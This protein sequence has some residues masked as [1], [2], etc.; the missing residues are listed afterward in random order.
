MYRVK[1]PV[2]FALAGLLVSMFGLW[3][4]SIPYVAAVTPGGQINFF[5]VSGSGAS[6]VCTSTV[7]NGGTFSDGGQG[8]GGNLGVAKQIPIV[9]NGEEICIQIVFTDQKISTSYTISDPGGFM[10]LV[11]GT[12]PFTTDASGNANVYL[13]FSLS[14]L[15]GPCNTHPI[16]VSPNISGGSGSAGQI[17]HYYGG[18]GACGGTPPSLG[19]PQFPLGSLGFVSVMAVGLTAALLLRKRQLSF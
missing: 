14:G 13:I 19:V 17:H 16:K 11:K 18:A 12:N 3:L 9:A 1:K 10:T 5:D 4:T 6:S 7:W 8:F 15:T 2:S